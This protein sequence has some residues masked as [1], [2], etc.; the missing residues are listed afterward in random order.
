MQKRRV[1]VTA[2]GVKSSIGNNVSDFWNSLKNGIHGIKPIEFFKDPDLEIK[3]AS[4]DYDFN[5]SEYFSF[6]ELKRLDRYCQLALAAS[7]DALKNQNILNF[8]DPSRVGVLFSSGI[9]GISTFEQEFKSFASFGSK[10]TSVFF[11]PK[12][13]INIAAGL[14]SIETKF[15]G[16]CFCLASACASSTHT[17]GEAFHKIRDGYLDACVAGGAEA[18][19]IPLAVAGFQNMR[20]LTKSSNPDKA[21]IPFDL[22]RDGFVMGEGAGVLFLEDLD[23][24]LKRNAKIYGEIVGYAATADAF[25]ITKPDPSAEAPARCIKNSVLDAGLKLTDVSYV[26]AHGTSTK[27]NDSTETKAL[28]LAFGSH[29]NNLLISSTK[30]MTGHLLGAAGAIEAIATIL[31]LKNGIIP[32]TVGLKTKDPDCD[33][34]YVPN[35]AVKFDAKVAVSNSFGFGGHNA[36]ICFKKFE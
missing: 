2:L 23:S 32:P 33:L 26:N 14:I 34:N 19:L 16:D 17:I 21:S 36:A 7:R 8:H 31:T 35:S 9:G 13:I 12:M 22:D 18:A 27:L 6:N 15:K 11:V 25:H 30:S 24:A 3:L 28:K 5:P 29:A 20:A 4:Y 10:K 1:V